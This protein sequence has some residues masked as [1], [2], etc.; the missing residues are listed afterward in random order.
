MT[1]PLLLQDSLVRS[2]RLHPDQLA[3]GQE[4][5]VLDYQSLWKR[6]N[7]LAKLAA[8]RTRA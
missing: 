3:I 6:S 8:P 1:A 4:D 5:K 2:A 7:Q